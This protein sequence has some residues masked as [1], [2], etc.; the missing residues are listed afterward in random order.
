MVNVNIVYFVLCSGITENHLFFF[1]FFKEKFIV[2]SILRSRDSFD[3]I[4]ESNK[5]V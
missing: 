2:G 4:L 3:V 1:F 5:L